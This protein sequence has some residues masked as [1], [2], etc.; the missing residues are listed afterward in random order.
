M[1][2]TQRTTT[3][4]AMAK[5]TL[6]PSSSLNKVTFLEGIDLPRLLLTI[7]GLLILMLSSSQLT[8]LRN[9]KSSLVVNLLV[10]TSKPMAQRLGR[11]LASR[12]SH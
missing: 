9:I 4:A 11:T 1:E 3:I 6:L 7:D 12:T 5:A 2:M 8:K 10:T